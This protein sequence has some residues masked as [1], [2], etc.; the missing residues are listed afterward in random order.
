MENYKF[1]QLWKDLNNGYEIY[2]NYMNVRYLLTKLKN[3]CYSKKIIKDIDKSPHP[4]TQIITL[5]TVKEL[6]PYMEN[7]EYKVNI[8]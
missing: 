8:N 6:F 4:K 5:K 3:N 7:I 2:Y 1:E